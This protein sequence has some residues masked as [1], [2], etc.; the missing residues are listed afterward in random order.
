MLERVEEHHFIVQ[1]SASRLPYKE[2]FVETPEAGSRE[3]YLGC[4][5]TG[6]GI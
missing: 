4:I 3:G 6:V 1:K 2:F 5:W